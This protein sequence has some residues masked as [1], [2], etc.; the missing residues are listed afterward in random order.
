RFYPEGRRELRGGRI[1][2]AFGEQLQAAQ[3]RGGELVARIECL[4]RRA[5]EPA[6]PNLRGRRL[7]RGPSFIERV[8][9][10]A[11]DLGLEHGVAPKGGRRRQ[12]RGERRR[13][14]DNRRGRRC[15]EPKRPRQLADLLI[16]TSDDRV[17]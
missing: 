4:T 16:A 2:I 15:D 1:D 9:E 17:G 8:Q 7:E 6:A 10:G 13:R 3:K 5:V 14:G 12:H 11:D